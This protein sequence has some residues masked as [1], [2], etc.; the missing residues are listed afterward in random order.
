MC[1]FS[2]FAPLFIFIYY[3]SYLVIIIYNALCGWPVAFFALTSCRV[4]SSP[5]SSAWQHFVPLYVGRACVSQI[6]KKEHNIF[7]STRLMLYSTYRCAWWY[8]PERSIICNIG[9][10]ESSSY[11]IIQNLAALRI[12][13][14]LWILFS[15]PFYIA[16][17][18]SSHM[19]DLVCCILFYAHMQRPETS[20]HCLMP[21]KNKKNPEWA[22]RAHALRHIKWFGR[23]VKKYTASADILSLSRNR[24]NRK[25]HHNLLVSKRNS[26]IVI[27]YPYLY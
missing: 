19:E 4:P 18:L 17:L 10:V 13:S 15:L 25:P 21:S 24:H 26:N 12:Q 7:F 6:E 20:T 11:I 23:K 14:S 8:A 9:R 27:S 1:F 22:T 16:S 5:L 2:I 3:R